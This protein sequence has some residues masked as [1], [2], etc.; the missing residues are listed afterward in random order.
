MYVLHDPDKIA[1][2]SH[3]RPVRCGKS[4]NKLYGLEQ[5]TSSFEL[6]TSN[7]KHPE[8]DGFTVHA[9]GQ[10]LT[11]G[12]NAKT[13]TYC[14]DDVPQLEGLCDQVIKN[15]TILGLYN[16]TW[17]PVRVSISSYTQ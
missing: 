8:V 3:S 4:D 7:P 17:Y 13:S 10:K 14:P 1:P 2:C 12:P 11:A 5:I 16:G 6:V 15:R 9:S